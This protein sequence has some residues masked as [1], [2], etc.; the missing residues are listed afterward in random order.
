MAKLR[1][2]CRHGTFIA[3]ILCA[4]RGLASPAIC[5]GRTLLIRPIFIDQVL[6]SNNNKRDN[7]VLSFPS[8]TPEELSDAI[9]EVV[10]A[11]AVI[12]NLSLGL[13]TSSLMTYPKL[14]E[15]YNYSRKHGAIIV[16]ASGNQG[17][18]GSID[19]QWIIPVAACDEYGILNPAN[20]RVY[21]IKRNYKQL[22]RLPKT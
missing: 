6:T 16:A 3:G 2:A 15:A 1:D 8:T 4:K 19:N 21:N 18:I 7:D 20:F 10:D 13:S 17:N 5:P 22:R 9:I 11:G 12:I 14:Q